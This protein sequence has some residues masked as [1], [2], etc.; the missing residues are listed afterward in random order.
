MENSA[1][2]SIDTRNG[3]PGLEVLLAHVRPVGARTES[4]M[5]VYRGVGYTLDISAR[6]LALCAVGKGTIAAADRLIDGYWRR[7]LTSANTRLTA[8]GRGNFEH[9]KPYVFMS[10]HGSLA[11]IPALMGAV[12][13]SMRMVTKEELT[14]LPIWGPALVA[15]GFIAIDRKNRKKA[16]AQLDK[17]K[18][19]IEQGVCVWVSPE[20]SR[21]RD[22][23][24]HPFKK[25]G[26][27]IAIDMGVP[28]IPTWI[29]GAADILPADRF[30][31]RYGGDVQVRF[32]APMQTK[33]ISKDGLEELMATVRQQILALS[34]RA[35]EVDAA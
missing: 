7:I 26:F 23:L 17:A 28:I 11:D 5:P 9:G 34:G 19:I 33:G 35:S 6:F 20:G 18:R 13:G 4:R 30:V 14:K 32:G 15:S 2:H 22:G 21:S 25:G 8:S 3:A 31:V 24:L 16:I 12:P 1:A 29:E 10:N 27:H